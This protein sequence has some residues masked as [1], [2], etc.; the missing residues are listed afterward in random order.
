MTWAKQVLIGLDQLA[1][2]VLGGWA[3]E[4]LSARSFRMGVV[5]P[6]WRR[7][8]SIINCLFFWQTDHCWQSYQ[9]EQQRLHS[10]PEERLA[11]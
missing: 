11:L 6:R 5:S 2:T 8:E 9:A 7:L 10:P 1:N 3:D 4:T